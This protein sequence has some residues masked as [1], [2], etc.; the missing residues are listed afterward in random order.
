MEIINKL[1]NIELVKGKTLNVK[2]GI[3]VGLIHILFVGII[4][5]E[6]IIK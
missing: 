1:K 5:I 2:I 4:I 3:G 6:N